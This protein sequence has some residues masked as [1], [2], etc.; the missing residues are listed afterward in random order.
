MPLLKIDST[1][2]LSEEV[3]KSL[4][5]ALSRATAETLGKPGQYVMVTFG[6]AA[7]LMS[8]KGGE[9]A[10]VD[11]RSIGGLN[12]EV[13]RKLSQKICQLLQEVLGISPERVYL[14]FTDVK[15][16]NWG[17]NGDTFG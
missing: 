1:V 12:S 8:G 3:R 7:A 4:L 17:W 6:H 11:V 10:F 15:G 16:V 5:V 9:A 2:T 13:N 14:N